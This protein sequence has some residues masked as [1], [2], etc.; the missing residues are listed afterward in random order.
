MVQTR[1]MPSPAL[2]QFTSESLSRRQSAT[3]EAT[4]AAGNIQLRQEG[5]ENPAGA[6]VAGRDR[7]YSSKHDQWNTSGTCS[8]S[9]VE[10][11]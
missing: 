2:A 5:H 6:V 3:G 4:L 7:A 8:G 11:S 10:V 1:G 9:R